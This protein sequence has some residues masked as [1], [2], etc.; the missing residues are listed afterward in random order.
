MKDKKQVLGICIILFIAFILRILY[1]NTEFWYDEAC[2]WFT[3][4]QDFPFGII[5]NL[6]HLDL[7]HTPVYFFLLHF[8]MKFFGD[9]E[10]AIRS[11]S[12]IFG[13]LSV[14]LT[15]IVSRKLFDKTFA[16]FAMLAVSVSPLLVFFSVE[17]R[18]YPMTVFLVLLSLNFLVD[19]E[20]KGDKKSLI[21]LI[22]S[23][24]LIPYTLVG[25]IFYNISLAICYGVYL[26]KQKQDSFWLYLKGFCIEAVFL[27]PYI[28]LI[29]D[30]AKMRSLFVIRHEGEF[31]F[32]QMIEVIRNF[33]SSTIVDNPY[34]PTL[35]SYE[36]TPA[37]ILLVIIPCGYFLYGLFKGFVKSSG[38]LKSLYCL[39]FLNF[40]LALIFAILEV[41]IFTMRYILYLLAPLF[42]LSVNGLSISLTKRHLTIFLAYFALTSICFNFQYSKKI[43][44]LK[45]MALSAVREESQALGLTNKDI[46][47]EPFASDAPYYFRFLDS[48]RMH[49]FDFHK[50]LRNPYNSKYYDIEQQKL[51]DKAAKYGVIYDSVF[52]EHCFSNNFVDY[53]LNDVNNKTESGRFVL[54]ALYGEDG[55]NIVPIEDLRNSVKNITDVKKNKVQIMLQKYLYDILFLLER[56]FTFIQKYKKGNFTYILYQKR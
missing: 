54:I 10:I 48:V 46:I 52:A 25:G 22:L 7:Q 2:S 40:I 29:G 15:Y 32:W 43:K 51:M 12:F 26:Y 56:D 14:P 3:A 44:N 31:A 41:N 19:F 36:M 39:F 4:K 21:K 28:I 24:I 38:F 49:N 16:N 13:I 42:I 18:M 37:L 35:N 9:G 5:D 20:Q 8:W 50:E 6:I 11:L 27:I 23:N 53:F 55:N 34:W 30:Y 1:I 33:F 17:A 45:H 47:I